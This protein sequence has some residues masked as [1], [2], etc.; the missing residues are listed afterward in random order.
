MV[1]GC[2][3]Y[4]FDCA[5]PDPETSRCTRVSRF[6][7]WLGGSRRFSLSVMTLEELYCEPVDVLKKAEK[8]LHP[9]FVCSQNLRTTVTLFARRIC[10]AV[11]TPTCGDMY[12]SF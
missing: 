8:F 11:S 1:A 7:L 6:I 5:R 4:C 2:V 10:V 3:V 12:L 9:H